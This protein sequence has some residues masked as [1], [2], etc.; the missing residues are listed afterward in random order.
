[1]TAQFA[2]ILPRLKDVIEGINL[3]GNSG[4]SVSVPLDY[5]A[6]LSATALPTFINR[7]T[8]I[9]R[10]GT[11]TKNIRIYTVNVL[12]TLYLREAEKELAI[13]NQYDIY[14]YLDKLEE[15]FID[16][17]HLENSSSIA[18]S[19]VSSYVLFGGVQQIPVIRPY[20]LNAPDAKQYYAAEFSL[21]IPFTKIKDC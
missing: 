9:Q 12:M 1:M 14:S 5:P 15:R 16:K 18:L 13:I 3:D 17:P 4:R 7:I 10:Q 21:Q 20:P 11:Q 19:G 2:D 6:S 8:G